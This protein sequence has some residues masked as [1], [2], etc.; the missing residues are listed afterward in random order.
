V[1]ELTAT[2]A[3]SGRAVTLRFVGIEAAAAEAPA[4][5]G[6][7]G[8]A[9]GTEGDPSISS[10]AMIVSITENP[11]ACNGEVRAFATLAGADP[12][13]QVDFTSPQSSG[14]RSGTA[15][16]DGN[17]PVRWSCDPDQVGTEWELTATGAT[18][19]R[20]VTFSFT[21]G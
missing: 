6:A 1:W 7:D 8:S 11:F 12:G 4:G 9:D 20:S 18:S 3:T 10:A 5:D 19:G 13:E 15:D 16:A 14:L 17:L 21:G 2:G